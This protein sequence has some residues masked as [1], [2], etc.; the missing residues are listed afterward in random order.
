[1]FHII[2][3]VG[4]TYK[5]FLWEQQYWNKTEKERKQ[6]NVKREYEKSKVGTK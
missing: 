3:N 6:T 5:C 2:G 4:L 1:M